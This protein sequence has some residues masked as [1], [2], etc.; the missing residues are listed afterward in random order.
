MTD[1]FFYTVDQNYNSVSIVSCQL[2]ESRLDGDC[3]SNFFN[4]LYIRKFLFFY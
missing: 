1:R 2:S 3:V 4:D